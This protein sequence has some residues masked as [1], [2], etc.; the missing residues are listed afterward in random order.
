MPNH[1]HGVVV[2]GVGAIHELPLPDFPS[3]ELSQPES[4]ARRR[5]MTLPLVIGYLKMNSAKQINEILGIP[6]NPVWQRNYYEHII[7][8]DDDHHSINLYV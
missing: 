4:R 3:P 1:F 6:G 7:R 2:I 5:L 8:D